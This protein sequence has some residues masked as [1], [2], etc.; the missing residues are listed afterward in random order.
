MQLKVA[1]FNQKMSYARLKVSDY[2]KELKEEEEQKEQK[3][4][5][6]EKTPEENRIGEWKYGKKGNE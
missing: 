4:S 1:S 3:E 5:K 6:P 2:K